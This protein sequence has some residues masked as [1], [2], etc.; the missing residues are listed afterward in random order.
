M[1][2]QAE[3][4][5]H[6]IGQRDAVTAWYLLAAETIDETMARLMQRKRAIVAAVTDGAAADEDGMVDA[7]DQGAARR[8]AVPAPEPGRQAPL[9]VALDR[10]QTAH[11][12]R[13]P[14]AE[15]HDE[16]DRA[17]W[18]RVHSWIAPIQPRGSTMQTTRAPSGTR[19]QNAL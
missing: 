11:E 1:H 15:R 17:R 19:N 18:A 14:G 2:D 10:Q 3:D 12:Q 13:R 7:V 6:R 16:H 9:P 5:C 4:R 8:R